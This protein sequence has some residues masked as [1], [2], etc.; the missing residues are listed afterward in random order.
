MLLR[1]SLTLCDVLRAEYFS[2]FG[3]GDHRSLYAAFDIDG[4]VLP[5]CHVIRGGVDDDAF[6]EWAI[7]Y[8]KPHLRPYVLGRPLRG[9]V[10][11]W[12]LDSSTRSSITM[13]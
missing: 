12:A 10:G 3:D 9:S 4:F 13:S 8:L 5:A 11:R 7:T 1:C 6:M 2:N